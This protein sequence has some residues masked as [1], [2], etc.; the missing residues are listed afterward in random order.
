MTKRIETAAFRTKDQS[1]FV[2]FR[3]K[4]KKIDE[5]FNSQMELRH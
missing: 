4:A 3:T 5:I 2:K 1:T